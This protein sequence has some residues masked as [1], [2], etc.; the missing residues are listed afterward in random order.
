[1]FI[2]YSS[3]DLTWAKNS[4]FNKLQQAGYN[5]CIDFKDFVPGKVKWSSLINI[6][7]LFLTAVN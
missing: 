1:V 2:S 7:I 3:E 5:V 6:S 4:L